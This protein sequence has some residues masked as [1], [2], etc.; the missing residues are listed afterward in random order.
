MCCVLKMPSIQKNLLLRKSRLYPDYPRYASASF[1]VCGLNHFIVQYNQGLHNRLATSRLCEGYRTLRTAACIYT[2]RVTSEKTTNV[3]RQR[4]TKNIKQKK[5]SQNSSLKSRFSIFEQNETR[6]PEH[7]WNTIENR[8]Y[9]LENKANDADDN[10]KKREHKPLETTKR[11]FMQ[12]PFG[13]IDV[14]LRHIRAHLK[15]LVKK[16]GIS[17]LLNSAATYLLKEP[18]KMIRSGLICFLGYCCLPAPKV[19]TIRATLRRSSLDFSPPTGSNLNHKNNFQRQLRLAEITELIHTASLLHDDVVDEAKLRRGKPC[20][21]V[22]SGNKTAVLAGDYLLA[23]ASYWVSTLGEAEVV[24]RMTKSLEDLAQGELLQF[25]GV[26]DIAT[27]YEKTYCKTASLLENSLAC[28]CHLSSTSTP[29]SMRNAV[30][31]GRHIGMAFQIIDDCLDFVGDA[32]KMGK[33]THV[34]LD[35]GIAT[36]PVFLAAE[37]DKKVQDCIVRRF[38][39]SGDA[40][41]VREAVKRFDTV[42]V[43]RRKAWT[44]HEEAIK[45]L[46]TFPPSEARTALESMA[47]HLVLRE[48]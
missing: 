35:V 39:R 25:R 38:S 22:I 42:T 26:F 10:K 15:P 9:F 40:K 29:L 27:Y 8:T 11:P 5:K 28:V 45:A 47:L 6:P 36:L 31:F 1:Q 46:R 44:E 19:K 43:A 48:K 7:T 37:R 2:K 32:S 12:P 41:Y 24:T 33:E 20:L 18:G 34:D 4:K 13:Y 23:R 17:H 21:H 30:T 14:E 3:L 16:K